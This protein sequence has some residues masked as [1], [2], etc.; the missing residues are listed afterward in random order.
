MHKTVGCA[1]VSEQ[2]WLFA[3]MLHLGNTVAR[4]KQ[5]VVRYD[6][7]YA[8]E[9][10]QA[11]WA[12]STNLVVTQI[13]AGTRQ[14]PDQLMTVSFEH[15]K[16]HSGDAWNEYADRLCDCGG[17]HTICSFPDADVFREWVKSRIQAG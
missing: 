10:S 5:L 14:V 15:V 8:A 11:L 13:V 16:S 2:I 4:G 9:M 17:A 6:S 12:P 3:F 1:E 7:E